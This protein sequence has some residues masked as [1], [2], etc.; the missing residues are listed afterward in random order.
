MVYWTVF[1][2]S[3]NSPMNYITVHFILLSVNFGVFE[4][5]AQA[6]P[7]FTRTGQL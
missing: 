3:E 2:S 5:V 4:T 6:D 1:P 7:E